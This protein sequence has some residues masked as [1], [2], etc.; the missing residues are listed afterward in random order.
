[1]I[2]TRKIHQRRGQLV[3]INVGPRR[4]GRPSPWPTPRTPSHHSTREIHNAR[5]ASN[6]QRALDELTE[7]DSQPAQT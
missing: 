4:P 1:M 6:F 7:P 5:R 3:L 2:L